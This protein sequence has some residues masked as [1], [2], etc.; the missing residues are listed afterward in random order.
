VVPIIEIPGYGN[1]SAAFICEK[2]KINSC[3]E[4]DKLKKAKEEVY[5]KGFYE[6]V[7]LVGPCKGEKVC[8]AKPNIR[9]SLMASGDALVYFEPE[10]LVMSRSGDECIVAL[11]DQWYLPYGEEDWAG[12]V[13]KHVNSDNFNT[14]SQVS[15]G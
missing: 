10:S 14:Y 2:L 4:A 11:N 15:R 9:E 12:V 7:M 13:R 1:T 8:N 3:K 6:G 5:L